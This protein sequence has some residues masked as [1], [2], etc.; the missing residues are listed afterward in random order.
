MS[1]VEIVRLDQ[2]PAPLSYQT[3]PDIAG[4]LQ[5]NGPKYP[6]RFG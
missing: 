3:L 6:P 4:L 1:A 2:I 5:V